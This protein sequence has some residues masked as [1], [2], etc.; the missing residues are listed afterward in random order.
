MCVPSLATRPGCRRRTRHNS[1]IGQICQLFGELTPK[2]Y[3][4]DREGVTVFTKGK[5]E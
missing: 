5:G 4:L 3:E 1:K 2:G